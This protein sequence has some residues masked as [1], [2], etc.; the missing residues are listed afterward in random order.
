MA[1]LTLGLTSTPVS[2]TRTYTLT[3]A[4]VDRWLAALR[5]LYKMP[6]QTKAQVLAAWSDRT[7]AL[8]KAQTKRVERDI[9]EKA[10]K[11]AYV[12]ITVT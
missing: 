10:A 3:D 7:V 9:A 2:G 8:T 5:V 12:P 1:T 6:T 11:A 4:H